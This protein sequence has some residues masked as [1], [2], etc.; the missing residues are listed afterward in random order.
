MNEAQS[1]NNGLWYGEVGEK[2]MNFRSRLRHYKFSSHKHK[3]KFGIVVKKSENVEPNFDEVDFILYDI[4]KECRDNSFLL[5]DYRCVFDINFICI[6][7]IEVINLT[8]THGY[9]SFK[10]DF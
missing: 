3:E 10:F 8:I 1:P 2:E 5:F 7:F 4:M 9:K 6:A